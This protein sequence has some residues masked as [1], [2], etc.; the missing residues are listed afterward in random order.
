[1]SVRKRTWTTSK[2]EERQAFIVDYFDQ[3]G[4]RHIKTFDLRKD[5]VA[6]HSMVNVDV[7]HGIHTSPSKSIT[8]AA[9]AEDWISF[10][11]LEKRE[12]ATIAG[13]RQHVNKHIVQR[14]GASKIAT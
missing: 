3:Q 12:P 8:V 13:Y 6:Y 1:M 2:G 14:L 10:V 5:A 4:E 11:T 7:R 9:A